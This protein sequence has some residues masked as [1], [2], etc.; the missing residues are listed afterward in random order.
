MTK[1]ELRELYIVLRSRY[2]IEQRIGDGFRSETLYHKPCLLR[3]LS[4]CTKVRLEE[5]TVRLWR[6]L[7]KLYTRNLLETQDESQTDSHLS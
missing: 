7:F 3:C 5:R 1:S 6:L 2:I 4:R